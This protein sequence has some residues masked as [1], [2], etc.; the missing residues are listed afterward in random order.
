MLDYLI[1]MCEQITLEKLLSKK[2]NKDSFRKTLYMKIGIMNFD[3]MFLYHTEY[4]IF[5]SL[6][7]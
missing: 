6:I 4:L 2:S 5:T 1:V 3:L 7:V